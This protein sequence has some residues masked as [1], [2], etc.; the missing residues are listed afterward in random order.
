MH[1]LILRSFRFYFVY[2]LD[3]QRQSNSVLSSVSLSVSP[4]FT[5]FS[6]NRFISFLFD[7]VH[8]HSWPWYLV[9]DEAR[10]LKKKKTTKKNSGPNLGPA[11][12]NQAQNEV[13]YHFLGFGLYVFLEIAK[14]H[15]LRQCRPPGWVKPSKK[16]GGP[17]LGLIRSKLVPK[18]VF[19]P[20]SKTWFFNFPLNCIER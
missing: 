20:F 8:D 4:V 13:F 6:H 17:K 18:L 1:L 12:L 3:T 10:F 7:I 16:F 5:K 15:R 9:T 11:G 2:T 14:D 19:S